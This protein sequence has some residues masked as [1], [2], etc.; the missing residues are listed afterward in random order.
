M[1]G[2]NLRFHPCIELAE[3]SLTNSNWATFVCATKT[4]KTTYLADG[5]VLCTGG[6]EVDLALH[7][8]GP[9]ELATACGT[10]DNVDFVLRHRNGMRSSFHLDFETSVEVRQIRVG[11]RDDVT[12]IDLPNRTYETR[13]SNGELRNVRFK[14]SYDDDYLEELDMFIQL[15]EGKTSSVFPAMA[16]DGF[17]TLSLLVDIRKRIAETK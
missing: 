17:D 13:Y 5:V 3:R 11:G 10:E 14:G 6:H 8:F 4:E 15:C 9:A 1:M 12:L 16:M 7:L 2:N